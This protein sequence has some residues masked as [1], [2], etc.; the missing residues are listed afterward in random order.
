[1]M[2]QEFKSE[3]CAYSNPELLLIIR[4]LQ[5]QHSAYSTTFGWHRQQAR[6]AKSKMDKTDVEIGMCMETLG[7]LKNKL[8][9][10]EP[11]DLGATVA[12]K[13]GN[14]PPLDLNK[15]AE[16]SEQEARELAG[17]EEGSTQPQ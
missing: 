16:L 10:I 7:R 5:S 11:D 9:S 2:L 3:D 12:S 14:S 17:G 15:L 6:R 4:E 13:Y 8:K 1:Q